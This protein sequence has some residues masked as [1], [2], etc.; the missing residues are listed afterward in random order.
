MKKDI[1]KLIDIIFKTY[2][3]NIKHKTVQKTYITEKFEEL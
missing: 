2:I 1:I 3:I